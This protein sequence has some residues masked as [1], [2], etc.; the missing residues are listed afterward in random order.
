[1]PV[2]THI[3]IVVPV[4][5]CRGCLTELHRR[6]ILAV[7][8]ISK[9]FELL[10]VN[11]ASPDGSWNV[12]EELAARDPRVKGID[13]SRNFGQ[14]SALA[15]GLDHAEGDWVVV[16][17]CD[18][19]HLP[20]AI[21]TLY[22][23]AREGYDV[24]F[25]RRVN[26][27]DPFV[28]R[29]LSRAFSWVLGYLVDFKTDSTVSNFSMISRTVV[30]KL[31][32]LREKNRSYPLFVRWL[33]FETTAID[34]EHAERYAGETTYT[35]GRQIA[36]AIQS[37]VSQSDKPLRL[38]IKFGFGV[39]FMA[40]LLGLYLAMR[41]FLW[42]LPV[43]GWTSVIVSLYFLGGLLFA[44]LGILGLYV[45]KIFDETKNR[46]I[47]VVKDVVNLP[48]ARKARQEA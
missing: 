44:N 9:D 5:G 40:L 32:T 47:Y 22:Q 15:A 18:L 21:P 43:E 35:F 39:S 31:R 34:V 46:P 23:K 19:Q 38:S 6:I 27:K 25:T 14:H 8:P 33:G 45:G 41:K 42:A 11:D 37:I 36:F 29:V 48:G 1:M 3:S 10:F 12:I 30:Q 4:Y 2:V 20:E 13:L 26:R 24:V 17:D 28:K 7:E 16:M